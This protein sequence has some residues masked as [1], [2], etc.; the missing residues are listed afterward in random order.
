M[1]LK[2]QS[3]FIAGTDTDIGK[4]YVTGLLAQAL[5]NID[6]NVVTQ[7]W[8]QSGGIE[9]DIDA[10]GLSHLQS[11]QKQRLP[12]HFPLAAS[13]HLA[14]QEAGEEIRTDILEKNLNQ[15]ES[16]FDC[17]LIEGS[18]GIMVPLNKNT[19]YLDCIKAFKLQLILVVPNRIGSINQ[20]LVHLDVLKRHQIPVLGVILNQ[21]NPEKL[22]PLISEDH[23]IQIEYFG[24]TKVLAQIPYQSHYS[25]LSHLANKMKSELIQQESY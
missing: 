3:I 10:H 12:Y 22:Y 25:K 20:C 13:P 2:K 14:A 21:I 11:F 18:G 17:V 19:L 9:T 16:S 15:L 4:T 5:H 7:K 8:C 6:I 1:A 23:Q 24:Q